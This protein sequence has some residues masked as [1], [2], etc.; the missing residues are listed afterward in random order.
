MKFE[1]SWTGNWENAFRGLRHPLESYAKSD[2]YFGIADCDAW[3]EDCRNEATYTYLPN[4]YGDEDLEKINEWLEKNGEKI[5][6]N[7]LR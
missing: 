3:F 5:P 1:N 4:D 2:S 7:T 6:I